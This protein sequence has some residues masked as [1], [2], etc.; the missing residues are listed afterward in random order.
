MTSILA[1][2]VACFLLKEATHG[3]LKEATSLESIDFM[4]FFLLYIH[5]A[6]STTHTLT[7]PV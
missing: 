1:I 6:T 4:L 3:G 2:L 7:S 5:G